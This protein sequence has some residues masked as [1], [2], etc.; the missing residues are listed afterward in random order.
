MISVPWITRAAYRCGGAGALLLAASLPA[1][2]ASAQFAA[3]Q[4]PAL[5]APG[6]GLL[7]VVVSLALVLAAVAGAAWLLRRLRGLG[8]SDARLIELLAQTPLGTRERIVLVRVGGH[9]LLLGV[10]AGSVRT[11]LV[12]GDSVAR[13]AD[14]PGHP[15]TGPGPGAAVPADGGA[16][17]SFAS[18]LRAVL[19]RSLGK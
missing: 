18:A 12:L 17:P 7:R 5:P 4:A 13:A 3:P 11:L 15:A 2:A 9:E 14:A 6:G 1:A 10:A 8:G 16:P 19:A